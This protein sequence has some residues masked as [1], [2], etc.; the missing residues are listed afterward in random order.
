MFKC[1]HTK[2]YLVKPKLLALP[3]PPK[4]QQKFHSE[5][6]FS[7]DGTTKCIDCESY[8]KSIYVSNKACGKYLKEHSRLP[9]VQT[10]HTCS[11]ACRVARETCV[12]VMVVTPW[13]PL[14][15]TSLFGRCLIFLD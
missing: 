2:G 6:S 11:A 10:L 5:Q 7:V 12:I 1:A 9:E 15:D 13:W 14:E 3:P 4:S 8:L